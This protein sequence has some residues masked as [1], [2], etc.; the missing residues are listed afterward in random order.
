MHKEV[1][2]KF[3]GIPYSSWKYKYS[4]WN[5][6]PMKYNTAYEYKYSL[7][8]FKHLFLFICFVHCWFHTVCQMLAFHSILKIYKYT[9]SWF[10]E[11]YVSS[12]YNVSLLQ[13]IMFLNRSRYLQLLCKNENLQVYKVQFMFSN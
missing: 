6:Q 5:T 13:K 10:L 4:L 1:I 12:E 3:P 2:Y 9:I 7:W 8:K 11:T